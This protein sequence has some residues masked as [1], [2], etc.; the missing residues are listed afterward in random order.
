MPRGD[1]CTVTGQS[2]P[3]GGGGVPGATGLKSK[4]QDAAWG[5]GQPP[6]WAPLLSHGEDASLVFS[7]EPAP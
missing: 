7:D 6:P 3:G 4:G 2:E 5:R 1:G